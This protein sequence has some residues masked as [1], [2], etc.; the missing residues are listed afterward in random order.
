MCSSSSVPFLFT[1]IPMTPIP[2]QEVA[3]EAVPDLA[4]QAR[5]SVQEATRQELTA[6]VENVKAG[7]PTEQREKVGA[8]SQTLPAD[9]SPREIT[10]IALTNGRSP[11]LGT[12]ALDYAALG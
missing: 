6:C 12:L 5:A 9:V 8:A 3:H 1:P 7:L 11:A 4:E 10:D 2:H